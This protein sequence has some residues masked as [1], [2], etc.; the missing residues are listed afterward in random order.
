MIRGADELEEPI[1]VGEP[2]ERH[3]VISLRV[4]SPY[5]SRPT[6]IRIVV[7]KALEPP[8][9]RRVLFV[10]PVE[11]GTQHKYGDGLRT[12]QKLDLANRYRFVVVAP[13]FSHWPWF[14][15]H[16]TDKGIRQERYMLQVVVP[17]VTRL[18]PHEPSRRALLGFSKSGW[19]A[20][21]LL[22]RHPKVFGVAVA[23]DAPFMMAKPAYGMTRV[24]GTQDVF[25][26]YRI[27]RLLAKHADA[28]KGRKRLA[29]FGYGNF[30]GH[31]QQAHALMERLGIP[32]DYADGPRR[33]HHWDGG[34]MPEAARLVD[35]LL[36]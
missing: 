10:L 20:F 22:L 9:K 18:Y 17:E 23:W 31:H 12:A 4:R 6:L 24:V 8:E 21:A 36:R 5:Q 15:D 33:K 27:P 19:G 3:G 34:W 1:E 28:V 25:E 7:P 16:P 14:A 29:H 26:Q 32:H 13:T 11:A 30:R 35:G 2:V